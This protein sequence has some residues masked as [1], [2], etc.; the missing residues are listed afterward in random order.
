M[1][2]PDLVGWWLGG[3]DGETWWEQDADEP[4]YAASLMKVPVAVAAQRRHE[5]GELDLDRVVEIRD[6]FASALPG[7]RFALDRDDDEDAATWSGVGS[8]ATLR[9]LRRRA[10]VVSGNLATDVLLDHV[11]LAEVDAV[12][13]D[14]G[15][16][17]H[18]RVA[19]GIEDAPAREA[20]LEN[21]VTARDLGLLLARLPREIEEI[22]LGQHY[23][24]GIPAGIPL[25]TWVASKSGWIPGH[26]HDTAVVRPAAGAPFVLA[27]L[28]RLA[29]VGY[30]AANTRIASIAAQAWERRR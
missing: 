17:E 13:R 25:G 28:T 23:R 16:G 5:R 9:E 10:L 21:T 19:R 29:G 7:Y 14:A 4:A 26:T 15:V 8:T 6:E 11:G 27:V 20:G 24:D 1:S 30:D 2:E 3:L 22:M 18:T 12:L